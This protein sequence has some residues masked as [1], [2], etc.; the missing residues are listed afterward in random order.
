MWTWTPLHKLCPTRANWSSPRDIAFFAEHQKEHDLLAFRVARSWN[1][2]KLLHMWLG[3]LVAVSR[4][5]GTPSQMSIGESVLEMD[6][7]VQVST[8]SNTHPLSVACTP[9]YFLTGSS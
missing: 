2:V 1:V 6:A 5:G 8:L 3:P 9:F 4:S 7:G